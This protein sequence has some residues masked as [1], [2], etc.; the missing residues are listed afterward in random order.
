ML[1]QHSAYIASEAI[2]RAGIGADKVTLENT[3]EAEE[4]WSDV[5]VAGAGYFAAILGFTPGQ[6]NNEG[7]AIKPAD[8]AKAARSAIYA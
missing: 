8:V 5:I 2:R 6:L 4:A 3:V 1:A 7:Q